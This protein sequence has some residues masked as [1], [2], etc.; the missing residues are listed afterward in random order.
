MDII[1]NIINSGSNL[2]YII[3][4]IAAIIL[5]MKVLDKVLKVV[6]CLA[7]AA[8]VLYKIGLLNSALPIVMSLYKLILG[9]IGINI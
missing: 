5:I 7:V 2:V 1:L 9:K 4:G 6:L 8:F 3:I